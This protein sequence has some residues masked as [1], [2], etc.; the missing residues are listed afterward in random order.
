MVA[1]TVTIAVF[2]ACGSATAASRPS[3]AKQANLKIKRWQ[4]AGI[5]LVSFEDPFFGG[6]TVL[7]EY[8]PRSGP[9][10]LLV[11]GVGEDANA[12]WNPFI[13][14]LKRHMRVLVLDLPGF[15]RSARGNKLYSPK[16]YGK[17]L[18]TVVRQIAK[19]PV[20]LVGHS[21]GGGVCLRFAAT[22]PKHIKRL[23]LVDVAGVLHREAFAETVVEQKVKG[24]RIGPFRINPSL[25]RGIKDLVGLGSNLGVDPH[26][27]LNSKHGRAKL[28]DSDANK[29][30]GL[31]LMLENFGPLLGKVRA[32]TLI[33]WGAD[34]P[35]ASLRTGK[36]L[37]TRLANARLYV[38]PGA[39]HV[40]MKELSADF[41]RLVAPYVR[42]GKWPSQPRN[43]SRWSAPEVP[44]LPMAVPTTATT[45]N[46]RVGLC[47][48]ENGKVFTGVYR[49][50]R[51]TECQDTII[52]NA[53]IGRLLL[54]N[55]SA[56]LENVI[57]GTADYG[58]AVDLYKSHVTW[59]V[60]TL[61]GRT[62]VALQSSKCDF[63]GL[64][65]ECQRVAT[66]KRGRS[67]FISSVSTHRLPKSKNRTVLHGYWR[68][69]GGHYLP[70]P[71][72]PG[73]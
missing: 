26:R 70:H 45:A 71:K 56:T 5:R 30:A 24:L 67:Y 3:K 17:T 63:V 6:R 11:H 7:R 2:A 47:K 31:A 13:P 28:L 19:R 48:R 59:T 8:G 14:A 35:I 10:A 29:I 73:D 68:L 43:A 50:L 25:P 58:T 18:D 27:V 15:G 60:G 1:A 12:D 64:D 62:G 21:L 9:V 53:R 55:S 46:N 72:L 4:Q 38:F 34:D 57:V 40:P 20:V 66:V 22:H 44:V 32:K 37:A 54:A 16:N 33:A 52:R 61:I 41:N 23:V 65:F 42:H 36:L 69:K 51:I 39:K 49:E